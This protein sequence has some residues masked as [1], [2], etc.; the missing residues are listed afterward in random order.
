MARL[1][2]ALLNHHR[3]CN[4]HRSHNLHLIVSSIP[5]ITLLPLRYFHQLPAEAM[6]LVGL[7]RLLLMDVAIAPFPKFDHLSMNVCH[8]RILA[9][10]TTSTSIVRTRHN[11]VALLAAPQR[12]PRQ[13]R[14]RRPL[15]A[16]GMKGLHLPTSE[17]GSGKKIFPLRGLP[18]TRIVQG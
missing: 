2:H 17:R 11:L 6:V 8:P 3:H 15:L 12:R 13:W 5:I 7:V 14:Q 9:T 16:S 1:P 10:H 18:L 4:S